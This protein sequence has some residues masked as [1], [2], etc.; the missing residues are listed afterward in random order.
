M[1]GWE[2]RRPKSHSSQPWWEWQL[3]QTAGEILGGIAKRAHRRG[4]FITFNR[5]FDIC[6]TGA[7]HEDRA[8]Q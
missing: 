1:I 8:S 2:W 3:E 6:K 4:D 5:V 7:K